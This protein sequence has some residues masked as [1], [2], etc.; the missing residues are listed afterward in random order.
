MKVN[1]DY[2]NFDEYVKL[3]L[4]IDSLDETVEMDDVE[5]MYEQNKK[6]EENLSLFFKLV[7]SKGGIKFAKKGHHELKDRRSEPAELTIDSELD[8]FTGKS[9]RYGVGTTV[10]VG[11]VS[12]AEH[13]FMQGDWLK[14]VGLENGTDC[15]SY[16]VIHESS[17]EESVFIINDEELV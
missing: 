2:V 12:T 15:Y 8:D 10:N 5:E 11:S 13:P 4:S 1:F 9:W 16:S 17:N 7:S 14:I 6:D 3:C